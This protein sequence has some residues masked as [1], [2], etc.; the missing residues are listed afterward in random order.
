MKPNPYAPRFPLLE[1]AD[2]ADG[3]HY[4]GITID[5]PAGMCPMSGNPISGSTL[6]LSPQT[7]DYPEVYAVSAHAL[8]A[9][10]ELVGGFPGDGARPPVR[11]MEGAVAH[12]ARAVADLLGVP[13]M[14]AADLSIG[15]QGGRAVRMTVNGLA[16]PQA[17]RDQALLGRLLAEPVPAGLLWSVVVVGGGSRRRIRWPR[18]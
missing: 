9:A 4:V 16:A 3:V 8:R 10:E 12:V 14:Y 17:H 11:S 1:R 5:L 2:P 13:V 7:R 18:P 6:W 15:V